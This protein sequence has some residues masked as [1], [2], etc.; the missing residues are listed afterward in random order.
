MALVEKYKSVSKEADEE[1][2]KRK[3]ILSELE[4]AERSLTKA[5]SEESFNVQVLKAQKAELLKYQKQLAQEAI[6]SKNQYEILAKT[7]KDYE[8]KV[9]SLGAEILELKKR[10]ND[11]EIDADKYNYQMEI[12]SKELEILSKELE[13]S[14]NRAIGLKEDLKKLGIEYS[15][16][17][18]AT[19][20]LKKEMSDDAVE[21][22]KVKIETSE[23][24]KENN[25][26]AKE[27]LGLISA[28]QKFAK[29][30]NE[31]KS[32]AKNLGAEMIE[33]EKRFKN[34]EVKSRDYNKQISKL[35]KEY[36][37]A[38]LKALG[39]D[40]QLK[41]LDSS[42]GDNQRNVGNYKSALNGIA[43]GFKNL[44]AAFGVV[45]A[46]DMFADL[47]RQSYET[48]KVLNA[49]NLALKEVF[50]TEAQV[51]YQ[52][53]FLTDITNRYGL[54]LTSTTAAYTRFSA[55]VKGTYLEGEQARNI[56]ESFAG[57]SAKLGL[58][59]S[60]SEGIFKALE[61]MISKGKIQAE[62]LRGQLGDRMAGA[63][64]LFA[65]AMGLSTAQLDD[66]LKK[67]EVIAD[68]VLPKVAEN[69]QKTYSLDNTTKVDSLAAAQNRLSTVWT[70]FLDDLTQDSSV[71][72]GAV[73]GFDALTSVLEFLLDTLIVKGEDGTSVL[74]D[75]VD[76]IRT[77]FEAVGDMSES[78]GL[79]D[80]KTKSNLFSLRQFKNDL[81]QIQNVVS[82]VTGF[83]KYLAETI[84]NLFK[85]GDGWDAW[86]KSMEDSA[87][88]FL[89]LW[90]K[91]EKVS[92]D[93]K[94]ANDEGRIYNG[95]ADPYQKAWAKA[96]LEKQAFFQ[97]NGKYFDTKTGKNTGKSLDDYID[98][99]GTLEAK[100]KAGRTKI[101]DGKA[102]K[103]AEKA[104]KKAERE[105]KKREREAERQRKIA[106]ENAKAEIE[107]Q[108]LSLDFLLKSFE[109]EKALTD[110]KE[111]FYS[112]YYSRKADLLE[113]ERDNELKYAKT[114]GE[115]QKIL[116]KYNLDELA[117]EE[118][119]Q[120]KIQQIRIQ[121]VESEKAFYEAKNKSIIDLGLQLTDGLIENE[122]S[123]LDRLT[124]LE[125]QSLSERYK[126][127]EKTVSD[128]VANNERLTDAEKQYYAETLKLH[129]DNANAKTD[130]DTEYYDQARKHLETALE[131]EK[132][133]RG[134]FYDQDTTLK[135]DQ[136]NKYYEFEE[137]RR[138]DNYKSQLD[139]I[140]AKV[141]S[142]EAKYE[143]INALDEEYRLN[144]E[145]AELNHQ[146]NLNAIRKEGF[147]YAIGLQSEFV[148]NTKEISELQASFMSMI[149]WQTS[150]DYVKGISY[151]ASNLKSFAKEGSAT[152]KALA[153][154]QAALNMSIGITKALTEGATLY[155]KII[156]VAFATTTGIMAI[157][158]INST[159]NPKYAEGTL[160]AEQ[161]GTAT[162]DEEGPELH[163][164]KNWKLK[165]RG[166]S[167]G[168]R[169]KYVAKG[170]KILPADLSKF[171]MKAQPQAIID[172]S[173]RI[174]YDKLASKI[175]EKTAKENGKQKKEYF[176]F[177]QKT[178]EIVRIESRNGIRTIFRKEPTK[179]TGQNLV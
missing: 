165:D 103:E 19:K 110:Q 42:V 25:E 76:I 85:L 82:V 154:L 150:E 35:S 14:K 9:K 63:F 133:K 126:L 116:A 48:I 1:L 88:R 29:E 109:E 70:K 118:E 67:G 45:S 27:A 89:S 52:K 161:S 31:A 80:E 56:F 123:R 175:A 93:I 101:D 91:Y 7:Q 81:K 23:L 26:A 10:F 64:K 57:A 99:D 115:R 72:D 176:L 69:L 159:P 86:N 146:N 124:A 140:L 178:G 166:Q 79:M 163:F 106:Y 141:Q 157:S 143:A 49:Q 28:Y 131:I 148:E 155:D 137:K 113:K 158:K 75:T 108:K 104:R 21:I 38:Q 152:W 55:A 107:A 95:E 132:L 54:E 149:N 169:N 167:G 105:A 6:G 17:E 172:K 94:K 114:A 65:S 127:D 177:D 162:V 170:D 138:L 139:T 18:K 84:G 135:I 83:I 147:E 51:A 24:R 74:S 90:N 73:A 2:N 121:A 36:T 68:D 168:A 8:N 119:K 102:E 160:F 134:E 58:S 174:D 173:E 129:Q 40:K 11:G 50:E 60:E 43:G 145:E 92:N 13:I 41:K 97:L 128:K 47:T 33:L 125:I 78:L 15:D 136:E 122:K 111:V 44:I 144:S 96:R 66:M 3:K 71:M 20:G 142:E 120:A 100:N 171:I 179:P 12:L 62:E 39:L 59:A 34:G 130:V 151:M 117:L 153:G 46:V 30:V 112:Y 156:G 37:E 16:L 32:K 87:N 5:M 61:Q 22:Q 98:R 4:K 53:E 164:D 77:L